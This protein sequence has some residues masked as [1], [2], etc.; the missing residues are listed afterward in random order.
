MANDGATHAGLKRGIMNKLDL[1]GI[2][3]ADARRKVIRFVEDN[4]GTGEEVEFITGNSQ[5]MRGIVMN[6]LQEYGLT[7]NIGRMLELSESR[8]IAWME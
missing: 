1:H 7:Y 3:H 4:W 5:M 8:I 6:V 2:R